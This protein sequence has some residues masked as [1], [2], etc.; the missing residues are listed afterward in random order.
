MPLYAAL[1]FLCQ[2]QVGSMRA[3][4][5]RMDYCA[6]YLAV[7]LLEDVV[8]IVYGGMEAA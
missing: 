3:P 1:M 8:S 2:G 6:A 5:T 7:F 4:E